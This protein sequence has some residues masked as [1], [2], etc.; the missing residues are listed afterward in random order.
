MKPQNVVMYTRVS[1]KEQAL[2]FSIAAQ[3][4]LIREY[5]AKKELRIVAEFSDDESAKTGGT[6]TQFR[7]MVDFIKKRP[8]CRRIVVEKLDRAYR[9]LRDYIL[10][11]ELDLDLHLVKDGEIMSQ[12][13][14]SSQRLMHGIRVLFARSVSENISEEASK[15]MRQKAVEGGWP[16][17]A[18]L[19]YTNVP[20]KCGIAPDENTAPIVR[21]LFQRAAHGVSLRVLTRY[22]KDATLTG[23]RGGELSRA[24]VAKLLQNPLYYGEFLWKSERYTGI[25]EPLIERALFD[26]VQDALHCRSKP[27][28]RKY[29]FT[30]AGLLRCETCNGLLSGDMKR[31]A[32]GKVFTY[33]SC[34]GRNDC[35][36]F[37]REELFEAETL[38]TLQALQLG[39]KTRA[40]IA[41]E[42]EG[43]LG[44]ATAT[45]RADAERLTARIADLEQKRRKAGDEV[46]KPGADEHFWRMRLGEFGLELAELTTRRAD[47]AATLD[48]TALRLAA[49]R[50]L[51]LL[52]TAADQYLTKS[53]AERRRLLAG[54][55][56]N[57]RVGRGTISMQMR[58]PFH[59]LA[60]GAETGNWRPQRDSNP[61]WRRERALS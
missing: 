35:R 52:E 45:R 32:S 17:G 22:A 9:N 24:T 26:R 37:Y 41:G 49:A 16:S 28:V 43:W 44:R 38:R 36:T 4:T 18:P 33:Y 7:K 11:D 46:L 57:Y 13:S 55:V 3:A 59:I 20:E 5:C 15:G 23:K 58:S 6:R 39:P 31:K 42:I 19:G 25:Y 40:W 30:F 56:S 34:G 12:S 14:T 8:D 51:E 29:D 53:P 60:R 21:E 54:L 27:K 50:P 2:G 47:L 61:C 10:L 1:S 48:P